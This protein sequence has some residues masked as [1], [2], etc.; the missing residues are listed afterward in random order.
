MGKVYAATVAE[1]TPGLT[2]GAHVALKVVHPHLLES[3]GFF[4]RFMQEAQIGASIRHENVV[5]TL[6]ADA[7]ASGGVQHNFLVMEYVEGQ[8]LRELLQELDKVPEEL[9]RHIGREVA[10][11]LAAIHGASVVHRDLKPENVLITPE[12]VVKIMDLGVARLA[13]ENMRLSHSGAFVGSV[14]YAAPEQ[15]GD[16]GVDHRCDL[17][18]V[19]LLLY[20]LSCGQ[21]PYRTDDF[22]GVMKR[23]CESEPRRAG[24]INPQLSAYFEEVVH[25]LLAKDRDE[26]FADAATLLEV[27]E[28]GEDSEWWKER[29]KALREATNR[30]LRRIRIPRE[31]AVYGREKEL[32][33]LRGLFERAKA[34]DGRVVLIEGEAGIGKSRVVDELIARLQSDG[35]DLNFLFGS[36]PPSGAATASGAFSAAYREHFGDA[37]SATYLTQTP[38]LVP[39]FDALLRGESAPTGVEQLTKDSLQTCFVNVTRSLGEER[40]TVVLIDDLHFAPDEGRALFTSLA[41]AVPGARVLLVGTARPGI[42]GDWVAGLTRLDQTSQI[43]LHR[44]GTKDLA[45]LLSDCFKSQELAH[46]LGMQVGI[47]SDGNPFFAFEIIRGLREGQFITQKDDGTWASTRIID[48][49]QIPSSVL[50]LVNARVADLTEDE[51]DVLDVACCWGF[52]FDP[53]TVGEVLGLGRIPLLKRLGQIERQHRLVRASGRRYV[54]DHHQVQEALYG[55]LSELLREEYHGALADALAAKAKAGETDPTD[56]DGALCVDLCEHYLKG[57]RGESAL[58]YLEAAQTHLQKGY[59]NAQVIALS[60][61]ALAVPDLLTGAERARALLR[62]VGALDLLGRRT[63]QQECAE[64]AERLAEEAGDD[65]LRGKAANALGTLL[66]R[67]SRHEEADVAFRRVLE[68]ARARGDQKAEAT[69]TGN[70]GSVS[71]SQRR[72]P[73][74]QEHHERSLALCHE[75][76]DRQGEANATGNLGNVFFSQGRLPEAHEHMERVLALFRELGNRAGEAIATGNLGVAFRAQGRLPEAQE[77]YERSL[78]LCREIGNRKGEASATLNLGGVFYAQGRLPEAQEHLERALALSREIGDR[79]GEAT[80]PGNLGVVFQSQGRLLE[81]QEHYER[82]LALSREIGYREGEARAQHNLGR[83]EREQGER[84]RSEEHLLASLAL[85]EEIGL[86]QLECGTRL[87]LGSLRAAAG[88]EEGGRKSLAAARDLANELGFPGHE[89]LARCELALLPGGEPADA[90]AAYAEHEER[91]DAGDR[92]SARLL[93]FR[94]TGDRVHLEEAKRLLDDALSKVPEDYH[95]SMCQNVRVNREILEAWKAELGDG[96]S[97]DDDPS[98]PTESITRAG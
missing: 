88:D 12:H 34:G 45:D 5:R 28:S 10:K 73:E 53:L 64:E 61:R 14:E 43:E 91:L 49:I 55:S 84:E 54:F 70:L 13:D 16:G 63:R 51:R 17:H 24:E 62:L 65:E 85:C 67:T 31:T 1:K 89:A 42:S 8:S 60:E 29:A 97:D 7:L 19:G 23:V 96:V 9:C 94:A 6:M 59:L 21:H 95:D 98:P 37:G 90:L 27:L 18:A 83:V 72:L 75:I 71:L 78:A 35:E 66:Y 20:E 11:G 57:T 22:R 15:F 86:R 56:L 69:A 80:A 92:R 77:H 74:A 33:R 26:R 81:A 4:R 46:S 87:A 40:P 82:H 30:P 76:G 41:M 25:T 47:K 48:E 2:T 36:Y 3:P 39:A 38:V 58:R 52:E 68:L 50:D 93:L 32:D 44:L 79:E